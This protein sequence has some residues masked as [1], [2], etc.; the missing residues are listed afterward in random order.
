M[1]N[2][3]CLHSSEQNPDKLGKLLHVPNILHQR[4]QQRTL[5]CY[6]SMISKI[7]NY[8]NIGMPN[9]HYK[10][11]SMDQ[12]F[13]QRILTNMGYFWDEAVGCI[14]SVWA[15]MVGKYINLMILLIL[16]MQLLIN[17]WLM[18]NLLV[19]LM[20]FLKVIRLCKMLIMRMVKVTCLG[21][22]MK[23]N[24]PLSLC[25]QL[26]QD[27]RYEEDCRRQMLLRQLKWKD[28]VSYRSI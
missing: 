10:S 13:S 5:F 22:N 25:L 14:I 19:L 9:L 28:F 15:R 6:F 26:R 1:L 2:S 27:E 21:L 7:S 16:L 24:L 4:I 8:F 17:M 11:S 23:I 12:E 18:I 20:V 3:P